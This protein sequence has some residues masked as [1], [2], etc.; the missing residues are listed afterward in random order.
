[1]I[2]RF[3]CPGGHSVVVRF[4]V[5]A[6]YGPVS[7]VGDFNDWDPDAEPL[8]TDGGEERTTTVVMRAGRRYEFRY[9]TPAGVYC[10]DETADDYEPNA[11]G[12]YNC[13]LDLTTDPGGQDAR[14]SIGD[15]V[16]ERDPHAA[17][18]DTSALPPND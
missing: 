4:R 6:A 15:P 9:V 5:P 14:S 12:G 17:L 13:I 11:Y 16:G 2:D 18:T 7:V 8:E 10:N 3:P 1:M